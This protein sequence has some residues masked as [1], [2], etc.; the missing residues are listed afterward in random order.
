MGKSSSKYEIWGVSIEGGDLK[1]LPEYPDPVSPTPCVCVCVCVFVFF[2][3]GKAAV[4]RWMEIWEQEIGKSINE[5]ISLLST[6]L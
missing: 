1:R 6:P 3:S 4:T 5:I 2:R